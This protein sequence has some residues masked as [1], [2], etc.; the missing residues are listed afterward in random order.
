[1]RTYENHTWVLLISFCAW[2]CFNVEVQQIKPQNAR[3]TGGKDHGILQHL[4]YSK[5]SGHC[6]SLS[7]FFAAVIFVD[8]LLNNLKLF[9]RARCKNVNKCGPFE[10][11]WSKSP[12]KGIWEISCNFSRQVKVVEASTIKK[13]PLM[14]LFGLQVPILQAS[15]QDVKWGYQCGTYIIFK[16]WRCFFCQPALLHQTNPASL[17]PAMA[18]LG[19]WRDFTA[20]VRDLK[21]CLCGRATLFIDRCFGMFFP[22]IPIE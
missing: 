20:T 7:L 15:L 10:F 2:H 12:R 5:G 21:T 19:A 16:L 8:F 11:G 22:L 18:R 6:M 3:I 1:M 14:N 13:T 17:G 4:L 9:V